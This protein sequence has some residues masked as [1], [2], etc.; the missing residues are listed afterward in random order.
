MKAYDLDVNGKYK[1][2]LLLLRKQSELIS[3][4]DY[5]YPDYYIFKASLCFSTSNYSE[6][7]ELLEYSIEYLSRSQLKDDNKNYLLEYIY[8]LMIEISK[9]NKLKI[10]ISFENLFSLKNMLGIQL[11]H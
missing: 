2:A 1:D 11:N 5:L 3:E 9:I 6:S 4:Y 8:I 7:K 10:F